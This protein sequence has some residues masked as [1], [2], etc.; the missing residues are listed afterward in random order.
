MSRPFYLSLLDAAVYFLAA[1]RGV[2]RTGLIKTGGLVA[3]ASNF[4]GLV[5]LFAWAAVV[6]PGLA[7]ALL[8]N[9]ALFL[10]LSVYLR[11]SLSYAALV[12]TLA[13]TFCRWLELPHGAAVPP[14]LSIIAVV[15]AT[16]GPT[17]LIHRS[18]ST[19]HVPG[20]T[21]YSQRSA[22]SASTVAARLDG[23]QHATSV[24]PLN[25]S[26]AITIV[27]GSVGATSNRND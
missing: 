16:L 6:T 25:N 4:V 8:A 14:Q 20:K 11:V 18:Y 7:V 22:S 1:D 21:C 19:R 5:V 24:M 3:A 12:G 17:R 13:G 10:I 2:T 23:A 26:A 9:P 15:V 27:S